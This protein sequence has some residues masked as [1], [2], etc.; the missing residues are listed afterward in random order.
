MHARVEEQRP[1]EDARAHGPADEV[2]S[3]DS[4]GTGV[5]IPVQ[6]RERLALR[7]QQRRIDPLCEFAYVFS[8]SELERIFLTSDF[9]LIFNIIS[10]KFKSI[11]C[12]IPGKSRRF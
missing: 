4:R 2:R 9:F 3:N 11:R 7:D 10:K 1:I 12:E 6:R 8:N 5:M